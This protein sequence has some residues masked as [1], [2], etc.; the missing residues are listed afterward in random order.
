MLQEKKMRLSLGGLL[1]A[2]AVLGA[3]ASLA[4]P[5][6]CPGPGGEN[7]PAC[8]CLVDVEPSLSMEPPPCVFSWTIALIEATHGC[9][10]ISGCHDEKDCNWKV[11]IE[12]KANPGQTCDFKFESNHNQITSCDDCG[13]LRHLDQQGRHF[14]C[15]SSELLAIFADNV[16]INTKRITCQM[17]SG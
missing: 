3:T 13:M 8:V 7:D 6:H 14:S 2:T 16:M 17:C 11:Y 4:R 10:V 1:L 9:C 12:A 5:D 15:G